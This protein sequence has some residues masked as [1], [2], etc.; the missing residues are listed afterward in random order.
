MLFVCV[1]VVVF[2]LLWF[3][4]LFLFFFVFLLCVC[5]YFFCFNCFFFNFHLFLLIDFIFLLLFNENWKRKMRNEKKGCVC[6][7]NRHTNTNTPAHTRSVFAQVICCTGLCTHFSIQNIEHTQNNTMKH[8][9]T[10]N[11]WSNMMMFFHVLITVCFKSQ[12]RQKY[13]GCTKSLFCCTNQKKSCTKKKTFSHQNTKG[14]APKWSQKLKHSLFMRNS[15]KFIYIVF[16]VTVMCC[17]ISLHGIHG[18]AA[19][20]RR[21]YPAHLVIVF[22]FKEKEK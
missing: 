7:G 4:F 9:V 1:C 10:L 18:R 11:K 8:D 14:N 19:K 3:L 20:S 13:N 16:S 15:S 5:V 6:V 22:K 12:L 2:V 21:K 17:K